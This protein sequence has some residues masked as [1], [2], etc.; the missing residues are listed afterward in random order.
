MLVFE[1]Q[2]ISEAK[3]LIKQKSIEFQTVILNNL[4]YIDTLKVEDRS[5]LFNL[6][7]Q[8]VGLTNDI[9]NNICPDLA[10]PSKQLLQIADK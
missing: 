8:A 7:W 10:W 6:C 3:E 5:E 1:D 9:K 2:E 4:H